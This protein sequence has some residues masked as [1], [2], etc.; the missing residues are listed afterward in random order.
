MLECMLYKWQTLY[1]QPNFALPIKSRIIHLLTRSPFPISEMS[2][3]SNLF[4]RVSFNCCGMRSFW[5]FSR[6]SLFFRQWY[7]MQWSG[8]LYCLSW[9][10]SDVSLV[11]CVVFH[12]HIVL[13]ES[14]DG[15]VDTVT[16]LFVDCSK[17]PLVIRQNNFSLFDNTMK[18]LKFNDRFSFENSN[19]FF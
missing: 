13:D 6:F 1:T 19:D 15:L 18:R 5:R 7:C 14:N 12:N 17:Y 16:G 9:G 8:C 2:W 3:T 4:S 11:T 10:T